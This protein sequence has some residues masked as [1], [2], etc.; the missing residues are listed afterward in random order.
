MNVAFLCCFVFFCPPASHTCKHHICLLT[1]MKIKTAYLYLFRN[2]LTVHL[3]SVD[4]SVLI[5]DTKS[6]FTLTLKTIHCL[7]SFLLSFA[8][9]TGYVQAWSFS[10]CIQNVLWLA[11]SR[12]AYMIN[13]VSS[14]GYEDD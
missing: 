3:V 2:L 13:F 7:P 4:Y 8:W 5:N 9:L 11:V 1:I 6:L 10:S 12:A 14:F